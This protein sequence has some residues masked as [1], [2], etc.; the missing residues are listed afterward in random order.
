MRTQ[1]QTGFRLDDSLNIITAEEQPT[2]AIWTQETHSNKTKFPLYSSK[3]T[4]IS[5]S[6]R[7]ELL[8]SSPQTRFVPTEAEKERNRRPL[9]LKWWILSISG[10]LKKLLRRR[11]CRCVPKTA[12]T[13]LLGIYFSLP[14]WRTDS[15]FPP[16]MQFFHLLKPYTRALESETNSRKCHSSGGLDDQDKRDW[17]YIKPIEKKNSRSCINI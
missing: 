2:K 8:K 6:V 1:K 13:S 16:K 7:G 12:W 11:G 5:L 14:R 10:T 3:Q 15:Y 17:K 9:L 4:A